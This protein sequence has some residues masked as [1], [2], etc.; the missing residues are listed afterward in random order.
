M[1]GLDIRCN[2]ALACILNSKLR[3]LCLED[4]LFDDENDFEGHIVRSAY[5]LGRRELA[6]A[7]DGQHLLCPVMFADEPVLCSAWEAGFKSRGMTHAAYRNCKRR[8]AADEYE[9]WEE[10]HYDDW[11]TQGDPGNL[12]AEERCQKEDSERLNKELDAWYR[13]T[14]NFELVDIYDTDPELGGQDLPF[15]VTL[16]VLQ[17]TIDEALEIADDVLDQLNPFNLQNSEHL[18]KEGCIEFCTFESPPEI[19]GVFD[20]ESERVTL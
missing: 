16:K 14:R 10:K 17:L 6:M 11:L 20:V 1:R 15:I 18:K 4:F 19:R 9:A 3:H 7:Q 2:F 5:Y 8:R 13:M 12:D